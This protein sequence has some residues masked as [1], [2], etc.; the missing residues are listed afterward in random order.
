MEYYISG[1]EGYPMAE[2]RVGD[3]R[4]QS[5]DCPP[6]LPVLRHIPGTMNLSNSASRIQS[7]LGRVV[8]GLLPTINS[9]YEYLMPNGN[10]VINISIGNNGQNGLGHANHGHSHAPILGQSHAAVRHGHNHGQ[11]NTAVQNGHSHDTFFA[12][13]RQYDAVPLSIPGLPIVNGSS[14]DNSSFVVNLGAPPSD[15][16]LGAATINIPDENQNMAAHSHTHSHGATSDI[17]GQPAS[18]AQAGL[19][20][21]TIVKWM[22]GSVP[23]ILLLFAKIMYDHRLGKSMI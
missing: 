13:D 20:L 14:S 19:N 1:Y 9:E 23:F 10:Q 21:R 6:Q 3:H 8:Q 12:G 4:V 16:N 5:A 7:N 11:P 18:P 22:E 15:Q 17:P 2:D